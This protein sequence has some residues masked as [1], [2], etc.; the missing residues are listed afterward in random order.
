MRVAGLTS[1][2]AAVFLAGAA[3]AEVD[4]RT[5][6]SDVYVGPGGVHVGGPWG[7]VDVPRSRRRHACQQ[8]RDK[9]E[10]YY[11]ARDCDVDFTDNGC[12]IAEVECD[13]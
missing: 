4:V 12:A 2:A 1:F 6:W 8:W 10:D 7:G 11:D 9:V 13:D 3:F 5:P